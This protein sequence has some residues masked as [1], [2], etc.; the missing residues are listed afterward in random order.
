MLETQFLL[1]ILE[2]YGLIGLVS[3]V[4]IF[5]W[6]KMKNPFVALKKGISWIRSQKVVN[7]SSHSSLLAKLDYWINFKIPNIR[8]N[9]PGRQLLFRDILRL[10]FMNF[11]IFIEEIEFKYD[12]EMTGQQLF[13]IFSEAFN[14]TVDAYEREAISHN[15]PEV[16]MSKYG[17]WQFKSYEYTMKATELICS[18]N[19]YGS[20]TARMN[21]IYSL[22]TAMMELTVAEAEKTLTML[23]GELTGVEYK[24]VVCG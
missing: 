24:G 21:A 4:V 23:N 3:A 22:I 5:T 10:K 16:V 8:M 12:N 14:E 19:G 6:L 1:V 15:I 7:Y 18:S 11:K 17:E 20:N 2:Q 13:H 9:D